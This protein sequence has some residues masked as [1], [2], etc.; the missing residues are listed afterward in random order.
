MTETTWTDDR[1]LAMSQI[2]GT[3]LLTWQRGFP[4]G[5]GMYLVKLEDGEHVVT[6]YQAEPRWVGADGDWDNK[7]GWICLT[8]SHATVYAWAE[9]P[10]LEQKP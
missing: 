10:A 8:H 1:C 4:P 2:I 3:V 6:P 5:T 9:I 7:T